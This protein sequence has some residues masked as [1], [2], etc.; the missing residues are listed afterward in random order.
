MYL[1]CTYVRTS[2]GYLLE[3]VQDGSFRFGIQTKTQLGLN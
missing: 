2:A 3:S 1:L